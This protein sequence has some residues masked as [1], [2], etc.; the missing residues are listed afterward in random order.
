MTA[1]EFLN[2]KKQF[3]ES[4]YPALDNVNLKIS[5]GEFVTILGS[6]GC[7]KT[8]L[9]KMVNRLHEPDSGDIFLFGKNIKFRRHA[10]GRCA[11]NGPADYA[12]KLCCRAA[13]RMLLEYQRWDK[14][15][16]FDSGR[17]DRA[18]L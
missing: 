1:I 3:K 11:L 15:S 2:V 18:D 13:A 14:S 8:T 10:T 6:S 9:I 12:H 17:Y 5:E 4:T 7:G 16:R